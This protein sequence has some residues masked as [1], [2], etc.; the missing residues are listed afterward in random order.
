M[1][2][3]RSFMNK[4]VALADSG[5]T[6]DAIAENLGISEEMVRAIIERMKGSY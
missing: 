2:F 1:D 3:T 5:Y 6:H 4:V